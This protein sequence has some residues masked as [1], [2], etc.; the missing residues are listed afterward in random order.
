MSRTYID[1][2]KKLLESMYNVADSLE[3]IGIHLTVPGVSEED[4]LRD[5]MQKDI[6]SFMLRLPNDG[7]QFNDMAV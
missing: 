3:D 4:R 7:R 5:I 2:I 1:E 6:I